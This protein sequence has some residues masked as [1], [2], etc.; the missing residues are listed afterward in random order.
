MGVA[1]FAG[2]ES[3]RRTLNCT[4]IPGGQDNHIS[5]LLS[6]NR[7]QLSPYTIFYLMEEIGCVWCGAGW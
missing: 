2:F 7:L 1:I 6:T 3:E 5:R 4:V